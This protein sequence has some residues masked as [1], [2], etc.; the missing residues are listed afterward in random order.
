MFEIP[1]VPLALVRRLFPHPDLSISCFLDFSLPVQ[2]DSTF[3]VV[4]IKAEEFWSTNAPEPL[5]ETTISRVQKL[6]IPSPQM[7]E[8]C[9]Q[10]IDSAPHR[11]N[12]RSIVY[13]HLPSSHS[14][15]SWLFPLWIFNYWLQVSQLRQF[16]RI[17]WRQAENW[18]AHQNLTSFPERA[19]LADNI[20]KSLDYL[21]WTGRLLGFPDPE[22]CTKLS[23]YL[24]LWGKFHVFMRIHAENIS[25]LSRMSLLENILN[26]F[27]M[28]SIMY[29]Q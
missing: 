11:L 13:N 23:H 3:G 9:R 8:L 15:S 26:K 29:F 2:H 18:A 16:V 19:R 4:H 27:I 28:Y 12:I 6:P 1:E 20:H 7:L 14:D 25:Y 10:E 17:P 21:P 5:D 24:S 22:P